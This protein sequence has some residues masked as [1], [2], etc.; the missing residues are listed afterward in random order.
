MIE[1]YFT[2][3]THFGHIKILEYEK[4]NRPFSSIEEHDEELIK[5]WNSVVKPNDN[6]Y[7]L[8]DFSL[9]GKAKVIEIGR[10]LNGHKRLIMGNHDVY[11]ID[12][13]LA[14]FERVY[15]CIFYKEFIL[16]HVPLHKAHSRNSVNLHG[17]LHSKRVKN[18]DIYDVWKE[19]AKITNSLVYDDPDYVCVSVEQS[20]LTPININEIREKIN[21]R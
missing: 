15:G 13:Y 18:T 6:V 10:R 20:N 4:E 17:H 3:D 5:R 8:G 14:V 16:S 11:P 9:G 19:P 12:Y 2:A 7:H 21:G 1:T